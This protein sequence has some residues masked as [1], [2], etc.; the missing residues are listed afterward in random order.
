MK[1]V[2]TAWIEQVIEFD[3][4]LEYAAFYYDL[5]NCGKRFRILQEK[6][7]KSGKFRVHLMRQYNSNDF[8]ERSGRDVV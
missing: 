4:E 5:E 6:K 7:L 1:R 8:P 2:I 3:S